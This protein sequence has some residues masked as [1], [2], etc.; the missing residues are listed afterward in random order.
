MIIGP[1][2]RNLHAGQE[3]VCLKSLEQLVAVLLDFINI[4]VTALE[5]KIR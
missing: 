3:E 2:G 1:D 5:Q 4:S